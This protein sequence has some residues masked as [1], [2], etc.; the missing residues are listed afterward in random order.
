MNIRRNILS[1]ILVRL[2]LAG[3]VALA[4]CGGNGVQKPVVFLDQGFSADDRQ[5]FYYLS[6]GSQLLP[7]DWFLAL[8]Q[9]E[10]QTLF[11]DDGHMRE[12]GY[13]PQSPDPAKNP[14]G[15]PIG[16]TKDDN[17]DTVD[18]FAIK[19]AFLGEDY[20]RENYP[21]TNAWMGPTCAA[22]H[23][24]QIDYQGESIR[25]EGGPALVDHQTFMIRLAAAL[26]ATHNDAQKMDRFAR[27][28]LEPN[29]SQGE[30]DALQARVVAYSGVL[31]RLVQ[32][33][34]TDLAYGYGRLDAFGAIL[35]RVMETGLGI[36]EN[37]A[38]SNAPVSFPF[39]WTASQL[40]WVQWNSA[41]SNAIA[42]NTGEVMGVY[43]HMQLTGTPQTGQFN[44]TARIDNLD[45]IESYVEKI[46]APGWPEQL[47]GAID[48]TKVEQ[49]K[50]L[51]AANCKGC[52]V[53]RGADGEFPR[54]QANEGEIK[55]F[56]ITN[57]PVLAKLRTD[58]QMI[59]N[60]LSRFVDPGD[61][62][63]YLP[64]L[65]DNLKQGKKVLAVVVL[66]AA[67]GGTVDRQL[68]QEGLEGEALQEAKV[69]LNGGRTTRAQ[70]VPPPQIVATY[71]A[72][73]LNGIWATAPYLHNGSVP[74]LYQMLLPED[75]RVKTFR[76]GS[77][78]FDP[79]NIGYATDSGFEF[80]TSLPGNRNTGHSGPEH[81][82]T[83]GDNNQWRDYS[84][85]QRWALIEYLKTL[86]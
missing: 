67:V 21:T 8:E 48:S 2:L 42:R 14:E 28:V 73:P 51:F 15:L 38:E 44:S 3:T 54:R 41:V 61:L 74:S 19:K 80:D 36:P 12:L 9:A 59:Q 47:F 70:L 58:P 53:I 39:L 40:D 60:V 45:R 26:E 33:N 46:E 78:E 43:A 17:P 22:C 76:V 29:W 81:T 75:Q 68:K 49:G 23:T 30:Q 18:S 34:A 77:R 82:Q 27:R 55:Q 37:H 63:P 50:A 24:S 6:Q 69:R 71:K 66:S 84:E 5:A 4:G 32:Q 83:K 1:P 25:I 85:D 16:F 64:E 57:A 31:N 52:H 56:I 11:R 13:I 7:Y 65:P 86:R 79:V 20:K 62:A 10:S 72:R 35:N